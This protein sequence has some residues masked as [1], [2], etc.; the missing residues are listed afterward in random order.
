M[1]QLENNTDC[2]E[3][4]ATKVRTFGMITN[5]PLKQGSGNVENPILHRKSCDPVAKY[6]AR[7]EIT[8]KIRGIQQSEQNSQTSEEVMIKLSLSDNYSNYV[9]MKIMS[10]PW[11]F[12]ND[13]V[14][15]I[16]EIEDSERMG[17]RV[18]QKRTTNTK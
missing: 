13:L 2:Y 17:N 16:K 18:L 6:H 10:H 4:R 14:K 3:R 15:K 5:I 11:L 8:D 12:G 9:P 1:S 7:N